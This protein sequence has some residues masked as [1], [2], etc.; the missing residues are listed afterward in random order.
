MIGFKIELAKQAQ[1]D[2]KTLPDFIEDRFHRWV[3]DVSEVG[4]NK[5]RKIPGWHDEPLNGK[6]KG[7][8]SIRL[9]KAY[10]AIYREDKVSQLLIIV[11]VLEINKHRY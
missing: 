4:L 9:N 7:Q 5:V 10:R 3:L 8:R 1:R 2:L 11:E 6:R